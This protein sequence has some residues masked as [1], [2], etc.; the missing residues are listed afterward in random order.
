MK[1]NIYQ[2]LKAEIQDIIQETPT[3]KTFVLKPNLEFSFQTGQ[4]IEL[5]VPG[6]GEAPFTP[7]SDPSVNT[8]IDLTVMN[9]GLI[10]SKLHIM[11]KGGVLGIRGP[12]GKGYPLDNFK[13]RDILIVG[14]GV[15]LAPLRSLI[16][17]LFA[18]ID[19][20]NKIVLRYVR[21][22]PKIL[23]IKIR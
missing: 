14:G 22:R 7:S 6:L 1:K 4:F 11:D 15:G 5:T 13:G 19:N 9:V 16:F 3:I 10:T 12:Y 17:S 23:C 8:S 2:P 18:D 21:A 20:Y